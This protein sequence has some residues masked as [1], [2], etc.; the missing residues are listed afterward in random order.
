MQIILNKRERCS[1]TIIPEKTKN[2]RPILGAKKLGECDRGG[3]MGR[4]GGR[5]AFR[6]PQSYGQLGNPLNHHRER[7]KNHKDQERGESTPNTPKEKEKKNKKQ[8]KPPK[9][10]KTEQSPKTWE[11]AN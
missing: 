6:L 1:T 9:K 3:G 2:I 5:A 8:K 11:C 4:S 7:A 10:T